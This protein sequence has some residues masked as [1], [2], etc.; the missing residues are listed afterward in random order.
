MDKSDAQRAYERLE[1]DRDEYMAEILAKVREIGDHNAIAVPAPMSAWS[2]AEGSTLAGF[3]TYFTVS[4]PNPSATTLNIRY[5]IEGGGV[6]TKSKPIGPFARVTWTRFSTLGYRV[7]TSISASARPFGRL[8]AVSAISQSRSR[9]PQSR[10][11]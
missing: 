2:F 6:V 11:S 3:Q 4:N 8:L 9:N 1:P 10:L 7:L 5:G